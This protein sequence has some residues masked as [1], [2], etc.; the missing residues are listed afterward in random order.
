MYHDWFWREIGN[1]ATCTTRCHVVNKLVSMIES[2]DNSEQ[3]YFTVKIAENI[4]VKERESIS[5]ILCD[6]AYNKNKKK[7]IVQL[8]D[9][10][11]NDSRRH[12]T[13]DDIRTDVDDPHLKKRITHKAQCD[14]RRRKDQHKQAIQMIKRYNKS[15]VTKVGDVVNLTVDKRDRVAHVSSGLLGVVVKLAKT[16]SGAAAIMTQFG[17]LGNQAK[18]IVM[19]P[20]D[21]YTI[22]DNP[23]ISNE[24]ENVIHEVNNKSFDIGKQNIVT[25][26]QCHRL[27]YGEKGSGNTGKCGCKKRNNDGTIHCGY[28]CGCIKN[29]LLCGSLCKCSKSCP[30]RSIK[31]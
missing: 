25:V 1:R 31:K 24:L 9:S 18:K 19:Y 17:M 3:I 14:V 26:S 6:D 4:N 16:G 28:S 8:D 21:Q 29:K 7:V 10:D 15:I 2:L 11:V 30:N 12:I 27:S 13:C 23:T 22:I 5:H 20:P